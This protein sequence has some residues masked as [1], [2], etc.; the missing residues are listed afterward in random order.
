SQKF[1]G[2]VWDPDEPGTEQPINLRAPRIYLLPYIELPT[3][4]VI[5]F[6]LYWANNNPIRIQAWRPNKDVDGGSGSYTLV[7][8]Q[9]VYHQYGGTVTEVDLFMHEWKVLEGDVIGFVSESPTPPL[10]WKNPTGKIRYQYGRIKHDNFTD[11]DYPLRGETVKFYAGV[12]RW[13]WSFGVIIDMDSWKYPSPRR[14][15]S[16]TAKP[17]TTAVAPSSTNTKG[18]LGTACDNDAICN[19]GAAHSECVVRKGTNEAAECRCEKGYKE[20]GVFCVKESEENIPKTAAVSDKD[21]WGS[22]LVNPIVQI[23]LIIWMILLTLIAFAILCIAIRR[24]QEYRHLDE[25]AQKPF[26]L[27]DTTNKYDKWSESGARNEYSDPEAST[28]GITS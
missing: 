10:L 23:V 1:L 19:S 14:T 3:C 22:E 16:T 15:T 9:A 28:S 5:K 4:A 6:R 27:E 8:E 26:I 20:E 7:F 12:W 24:K 11:V 17:N 2:K 21:A 18:V 13:E 25:T